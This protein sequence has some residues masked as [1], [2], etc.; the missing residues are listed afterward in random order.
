MTFWLIH[1][2]WHDEA[3]WQWLSPVLVE[4]GHEVVTPRLPI[5]DAEMQLADYADA[6]LAQVGVVASPVIVGHSM[7]SDV[8]AI[9]G[10]RVEGARVVYLCPRMAIFEPRDGEPETFW[11]TSFDGV[12]EDSAGRSFW[13]I[14]AAVKGLYRAIDP[15][16]AEGLAR[17]LRPQANARQV[18]AP[19]SRVPRVPSTFIY[20]VGDEIFPPEW[21]RW[22]AQNLVG[23]EPIEMAGGHFP[24]V[25]RPAELAALLLSL[26]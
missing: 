6:V 7:S 17:R 2:A 23:V 10:G 1:G 14:D 11:E 20:S 24:M 25:E 4:A 3:C 21:S 26:V 16:I 5:D 19:I 18:A 15:E 22:A 8:A 13:P 9:L 12:V